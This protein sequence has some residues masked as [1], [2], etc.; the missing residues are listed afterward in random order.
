MKVVLSNK[1]YLK[2]D[3]ELL[4]RLETNLTYQIFEPH[5][6]KQI[7]KIIRH[8]GLV[9][10]G[11]Y[12]MPTSRMD[13][14]EDQDLT[15]IDKRTTIWEDFPE[16]KFTLRE[17]QAEIYE[18]VDD[19][20]IINAKPGF[21]KTIL[22]LALAA[23]LG[24]KTLVI[25]TTTAIRDMWISEVRKWFDIEPGIIGS[26]MFDHE[27][28][29]TI[30]NI[31]TLCKHGTA[32]ADQFGLIIVD[33]MHHTPASTF[34]RLLFESKA[35]YKIGLSGTL[36]RKD[37]LQSLFKDF[38][39]FKVYQ[40]AVANTIPPHIHLYDIPVEVSGNQMIP[41]A[42]KVNAI[43]ENPRYRKE[44]LAIANCYIA[45]GHKVLIVSDRIEFLKYIHENV[46][47][48]SAAF[49]GEASLEDRNKYQEM[50]SN[51]ELDIFCASQN[52]FSE[53]ISQDE[54]SCLILGSP[55]GNN[56]SLVEQLA[57]R[58]MRKHDSKLDPVV[59]DM[60]LEGWTGKRHRRDRCSIYAKNGWVC[61]KMNIGKL[62]NQDKKAFAKLLKFKV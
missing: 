7:P 4:K 24:Q 10:R 29:I 35:R 37:G 59:A 57:G 43:L 9:A 12:W 13:L 14:L 3:E 32:L 42:L 16:P 8:I 44:V 19:S 26:G 60:G 1:L 61:E 28:P 22:A 40:P 25:C 18:D 17:D 39:G 41:W 52:I 5:S 56:E 62:I 30:G 15:V 48:R 36:V 21:G 54:L 33:E 20:C 2:P 38:F 46:K 45:M 31:Q 23:K 11:T 34:T 51:G 58:V 49:I 6:K 55:I 47:G 50:M 53:G 27:S